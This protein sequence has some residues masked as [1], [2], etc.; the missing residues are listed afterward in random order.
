MCA[1]VR[2]GALPHAPLYDVLRSLLKILVMPPLSLFVLGAV[3]AVVHKKRPRLGKTLIGTA[4]VGLFVLSLPIV[5]AALTRALQRG[6][7]LDFDQLP[8]GPRAIVVLGADFHPHAPEY[9]GSTVGMLSLERLRFTARLAR[10]TGLPVLTTGGAQ[11]ENARP[12]ATHMAETLAEDFG[13]ETRWVETRSRTTRENVRFAKEILEA[14]GIASVYLVTHAWHMPR[15]LHETEAAA[16]DAVPAATLFRGWPA[17]KVS[18]YLPSARALRES[19]WALH[20]W[21]GRAWYAL[22]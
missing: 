1:L 4:V 2:R 10:R 15:A 14:E 13:V 16:L 7:A 11:A 9:G 19:S 22:T 8:A 18:S 20:E 3:G 12:L 17:A 21:I 5:S 6:E